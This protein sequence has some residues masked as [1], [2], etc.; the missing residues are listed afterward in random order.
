MA[1]DLAV[2][3][4]AA[5]RLAEEPLWEVQSA[6]L[7]GLLRGVEAAG[8]MLDSARLRL[9][10]EVDD[11]G[12][13]LNDGAVSTGRWVAEV[14]GTTPAAGVRW[15][16]TAT[17]LARRF[18][19]TGSALAGG[20]VGVWHAERLVAVLDPVRPR[21][22]EA[23]VNEAEAHLLTLVETLDAR[24]FVRACAAMVAA[25]DPDGSAPDDEEDPA[26]RNALR[27]SDATPAGMR[28]VS[29]WLDDTSAA[30]LLSALTPLAAP[31][32]LAR[33]PGDGGDSQSAAV[34]H[35]RQGGALDRRGAPRRMADALLALA[36][37]GLASDLLP[38]QGGA[39][40][41]VTVT[42][43]L[44][45]LRGNDPGVGALD[46]GGPVSATTARM[47]ACE[48]RVVPVV[49]GGAG[50]P[51][52]VGRDRRTVPTAARLALVVR[53]DGCAFPGCGAPPGWCDA[54]HIRHW[55]DGG[56]TDLANLVLLCGAH[57]RLTHAS[58]WGIRVDPDTGHPRFRPPRHVDPQQRWRPAHNA[59]G[60]LRT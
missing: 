41:A 60:R 48:A 39:R 38:H 11:R 7:A 21:V 8:R 45:V 20:R 37:I 23:A 43:S 3:H 18:P 34:P 19:A 59:P 22:D 57:H 46:W 42:I 56:P 16:G 53:D 36:K 1:T 27:I 15:V 44:E 5:I 49:L 4:D 12:V 47:L 28:R 25:L 52:D 35:R 50:Q 54:H 10:A 33:G 55:A 6:D 32:A 2:L 14:I 51:L 30:V 17:A 29:G 9:I 40:P 31:G 58:R 24:G 13:A 26:C